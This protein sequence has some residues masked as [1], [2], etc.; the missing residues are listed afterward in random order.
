MTLVDVNHTTLYYELRGNGPSVMFVSGASGDAGHWT[1]V[2]DALSDTFTVLTYDRRANSR[3]PRPQ[4]WTAAPIDEQADDAAELLR[5][6]DLAPVV[7]YGNSSG[8]SIVTSILLRH[9]EVLRG[10]ILHEPPFWQ[11]TAGGEQFNATLGQIISEGMEE[12]GPRTAMERF[13]R[14]VVG[15]EVFESFDPDLRDRM[16][17][18]GEAFFGLEL[19]AVVSY[20]PTPD[21]L[22]AVRVPCVTAAGVGNRDP[23][24]ELHWFYEASQWAASRLGAPFIETPGVH[25]PQ[26]SHPDALVDVLRPLLGKLTAPQPES[27]HGADRPLKERV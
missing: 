18:N 15:N 21:Q 25:V 24:G 7:A 5:A 27:D 11:V 23:A 26:A 17:G 10:A 19:E 22:G 14:F 6:L 1:A 13:L 16:L 12:G 20:L 2:A 4:N 3:S 9:P 8:A